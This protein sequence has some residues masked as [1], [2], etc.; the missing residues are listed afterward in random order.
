MKLIVDGVD[1]SLSNVL[2]MACS[3]PLENAGF[4]R[5]VGTGRIGPMRTTILC[6]CSTLGQLRLEPLERAYHDFMFL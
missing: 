1:T 4:S 2:S 5:S 3:K 6:F